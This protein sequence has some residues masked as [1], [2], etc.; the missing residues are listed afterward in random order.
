MLFVFTY[1]MV[2][3]YN[4]KYDRIETNYKSEFSGEN[5]E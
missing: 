1:K 4:K 5:N 3:E 2:V